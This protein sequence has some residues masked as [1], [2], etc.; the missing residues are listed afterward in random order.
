MSDEQI[1]A[2]LTEILDLQKQSLESRNLI[3]QKQQ[4]SNPAA[5]PA[6]R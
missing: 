5:E 2:L 1:I 4:E 3:L 6:G